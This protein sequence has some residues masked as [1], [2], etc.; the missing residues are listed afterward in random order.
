MFEKEK[1]I[2]LIFSKWPPEISSAGRN[3]GELHPPLE[4]VGKV[5]WS[6]LKCIGRQ[7]QRQNEDKD[8]LK[9]AVVSKRLVGKNRVSWGVDIYVAS[10]ALARRG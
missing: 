6:Y 3:L 8:S 10:S 1:N 9:L 5:G 4:S 2:F 7:R